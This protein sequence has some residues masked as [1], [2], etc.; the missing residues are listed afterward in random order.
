MNYKKI[1]KELSAKENLPVKKLEKEMQAAINAA[2]LNCTVKE[3][4]ETGTKLTKETIYRI[5]V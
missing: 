5:I 3:F 2:G 1:L 4:I